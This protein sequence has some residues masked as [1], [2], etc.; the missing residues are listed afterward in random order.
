MSPEEIARLP[1]HLKRV[2]R[3]DYAAIEALPSA[4]PFIA[5]TCLHT[6]RWVRDATMYAN[7]PFESSKSCPKARFSGA[8][9]QSMLDY[10][11]VA[12]VAP[13]DV[14]GTVHVFPV[15]EVEKNRLRVIKHTKT[16]NAALGETLL[17]LRFPS[18]RD[19]GNLVHKGECFLAL[20]FSAWYDAFELAPEVGKMF[21][22]RD[23]AGDFFRLATLAMGQRQACE[24]AHS[25]TRQL[26]NFELQSHVEVVIDNVVFVG[27]REA[28]LADARRFVERCRAARAQIN[29]D[30]ADLEALVQ[31]K[32]DWCGVHLDMAAKTTQLTSKAVNRTAASWE[33]RAHWTHRGFAA[34]VGLLFWSCGIIDA[35]V[36]SYFALLGFISRT[37]RRLTEDPRFWD[38]PIAVPPAVVDVLADWTALVAAN[39]PRRVLLPRDPD[40]VMATDASAWGWGY[41]A[42]CTSSGEVLCHGE[43]WSDAMV[44]TFGNRLYSSVTAEPQAISLAVPHLLQ[45]RPARAIFLGTD[46]SASRWAFTRTF[47]SRSLDINAAISR[48]RNAAPGVHIE[49][50]HVAG[51]SN[52]ADLLSR[53]GAFAPEDTEDIRRY[54]LDEVLAPF[55]APSS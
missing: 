47:S 1:L 12:R 52:R 4:N 46:N 10:G 6:L 5:Q 55:S 42:C 24:V 13:E 35:P 23:E 17:K 16:A 28:V 14:R 53:G 26:L 25:M 30:V 18:K 2:T 9:V 48:L 15:P 37:S 36:S 41:V 22:F 44:R 31:T 34:H 38:K 43:K 27:S 29:E 50:R 51:K 3:L 39:A 33:R 7:V 40:W 21:C 54:L 32:G 8:Q 11:I 19:I 45:R 20:D 49:Y